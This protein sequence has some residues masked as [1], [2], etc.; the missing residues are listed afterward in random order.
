VEI[1]KFNSVLSTASGAVLREKKAGYG[2][3]FAETE[4][5]SLPII[6]HSAVSSMAE[7]NEADNYLFNNLFLIEPMADRKTETLL[8]LRSG[9]PL[10]LYRSF[11]NGRVA[12]FL[13]SI[14]M[15]WNNFPLRPF[16]V[17]F[18]RGLAR[19]LSGKEQRNGGDSLLR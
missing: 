12:L 14:D 15:A 13:S 4:P 3:D 17:P 16:Y 11:G 6:Q 5:L 19:N 18:V 9:D 7:L 2:R 1:E 10:L 8:R